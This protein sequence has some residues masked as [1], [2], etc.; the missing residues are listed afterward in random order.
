[1]NK[2]IMSG[3]EEEKKEKKKRKEELIIFKSESKPDEREKINEKIIMVTIKIWF[4][5]T[6]K[7][8]VFK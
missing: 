6:M 8:E 2:M 3:W 7:N 5:Y 4:R 1:M